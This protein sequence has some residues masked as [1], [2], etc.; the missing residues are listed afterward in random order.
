MVVCQV[1][2]W[3]QVDQ[4]L[5][6]CDVCRAFDKAP[7]IP[8]D[9]TTTVSAFN[10]K[11]QVGLLFL[12]ALIVA[13]AMDVFPKYSALQPAQ[14]KNPQEVWGVFCAGWLGAFGPPKCIQ[15]DEGGEWKNEIRTDFRT[16]RRI[17]L[18]FQGVGA[19]P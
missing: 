10:E 13:H 7:H 12:G 17:K 1:N 18:Q 2:Q 4:V 8:I 3:N 16:E 11:V 5:E 15:M 6:T 19:P 14:S 9:G